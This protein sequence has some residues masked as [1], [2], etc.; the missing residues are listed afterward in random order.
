MC[1][2]ITPACEDKM[3]EDGGKD[4]LKAKGLENSFLFTNGNSYER[5]K[6][7]KQ[8]L[9]MTG[10]KVELNIYF[11]SFFPLGFDPWHSTPVKNVRKSSEGF[12][13][14][15][16]ICIE[17]RVMWGT[18][19]NIMM[20]LESYK[21][22]NEDVMLKKVLELETPSMVWCG[23]PRLILTWGLS[24]WMLFP[25]MHGFSLTQ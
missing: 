13:H 5:R 8:N 14:P 25:C 21:R 16:V 6:K 7:V 11:W 23:D 12:R 15:E 19:H 24:V 10:N 1:K 18:K 9:N 2:A 4:K 3:D 22:K 17:S 20:M